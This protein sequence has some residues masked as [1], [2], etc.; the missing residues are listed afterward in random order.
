[1]PTDTHQQTT[2]QSQTR[3]WE[4]AMPEI[5]GLLGALGNLIP[6]SGVNGTE[7]G[8]INQM[9]ANGQAGNPYAPAVGNVATT[10]L[11]GGNATAEVP[12][13][14]SNLDAYKTEMAPYL[15]TN[16]S[17]VNNPQVQA[18]LQT[19]RDDTTNQVN[20]QFAAGGRTG[21]G[22]N[23][24]TLARGIAQGEAPIILD[25]A[26]RDTATRIGAA[27]SVYGAGNTT[28]GTIANMNQ[29]GNTNM[30][31]GVT[32]ANDALTARNWGPQQILQA[33]ELLKSIPASNL[34]LLANIGIPLAE[35]GTNSNGT[36]N[37]NAS[38]FN[39]MGV[40][41]GIGNLFSA[42]AGGTSALAGMGQAAAGLGSG[43]LGLLGMI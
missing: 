11:N 8:A 4:Q 17:T 33:Q 29:T 31:N 38:S 28:A 43:L 15:D 16:Y 35:L 25:Q 21:S 14:Q 39:P 7:T 5:S 30:E 3:P 23:V 2:S 34:G 40:V 32:A 24:Q 26:N 42:P 20:G 13:V 1:M 41:G 6:N 36:S 10:L 22:M 37:T 12:T 27:N 9:T 19:I 18:A